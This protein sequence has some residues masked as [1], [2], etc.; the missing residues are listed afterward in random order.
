MLLIKNV[1]IVDAFSDFK[2]QVLIDNGKIIEVTKGEMFSVQ[3]SSVEVFD[4]DGKILMPSF[5]DMH[6]HFRYP[7]QTAK[8]DLDSGTMAAVAGG[9]GFV[10]LMP[11]TNP[12]VS[13]ASL[14][15][16]IETEIAKYNRITAIQT[17]SITKDFSG[18]DL[19]HFE[20]ISGVTVVTE[21]GRD[22]EKTSVMLDAMRICADNNLIMSC[23][24][25][26][27]SLAQEARGYRNRALALLREKNLIPKPNKIPNTKIENYSVVEEI[28]ENLLYANNL[29]HLAEDVATERN[30]YLA[31]TAGCN[32]H[33]AH[34][35]TEN[36]LD[37]IRRGKAKGVKLT[38]EG[39]PHHFGL[40]GDRMP[41]LHYLVNPPLRSEADRQSIVQGLLDGTIDVIA[42]DH[43]PH[44]AEDK[45][46]GAPGF[47]GLETAFGV[48]YTILVKQ[49][50]LSLS[51]LSALLSYNGAKILGLHKEN[52]I[53]KNPIG[54]LQ[55]D[56]AANFVLVD[57]DK[58]WTVDSSVFY[59]KGKVCPFEGETLIGKIVKTWY[60]GKEVFS[61][62]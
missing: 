55:K 54:L 4:G 2:G 26:D 10:V 42:T 17:L 51:K 32:V 38:C 18:E 49:N 22:V 62:S 41:L 23:H 15:K 30:I 28:N 59:T 13:S 16:E 61:E 35:S 7:G 20:D 21:D 56:F 27:V 9:Y 60:K 34:V 8:E 1:R 36:S 53:T 40:S 33:I 57:A 12:I 58:N 43:A 11:N 19:S 14:V 31:E 50:G 39:T 25:E 3:D 46:N 44:T 5:V 47:S 6:V 45:A 37:A 24:S 29:L 52:A 48:S